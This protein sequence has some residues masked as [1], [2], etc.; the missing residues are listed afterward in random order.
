MSGLK[1]NALAA[2]CQQQNQAFVRFDYRGHGRSSGRF[3]DLTI[4]EWFEDALQI[5]DQVIDGPV[6][7]IGSSM[8]G[9]VM[10]LVARARPER[11]VGMIGIS[12]APD[13]THRVLAPSLNEL[14]RTTL[15][16]DGVIYRPSEYSDEP[17]PITARLLEQGERYRVL[18]EDF[19]VNGAVDAFA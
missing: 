11:I 13:F 3:E 9:W 19:N 2:H 18:D 7:L 12:V 8:G 10:S 1:A 15:A 6:L 4:A 14:E 5:V 17:Y 16:R